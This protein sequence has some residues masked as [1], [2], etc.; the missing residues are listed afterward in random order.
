MKGIEEC[1]ENSIFPVVIQTAQASALL[2][3][4]TLE[5]IHPPRSCGERVNQGTKKLSISHYIKEAFTL[6]CLC[7]HMQVQRGVFL[8]EEMSRRGG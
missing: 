5:A 3:E 7:K 1:W 4:S 8:G 2:L 6:R